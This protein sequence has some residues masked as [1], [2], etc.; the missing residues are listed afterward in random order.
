MKKVYLVRQTQ[1][2]DYYDQRTIAVFTTKAQAVELCRKLNKEYA[3]GVVLNEKGDFV[4][5]SDGDN[6]HY[7]DWEVQA[8]NPDPINFI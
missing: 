7:Y 4:E 1:P 2:I 6:L 5:L 8:V 3:C